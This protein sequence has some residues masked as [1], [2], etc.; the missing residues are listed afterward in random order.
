M[1]GGAVLF[2]RLAYPKLARQDVL[3]GSGLLL[4]ALFFFRRAVLGHGILFRRDISLVWYPQVESFVRSVAAGS[5]PLWD[6]YRGFG[7]PLLADPSAEILYPF[8][9]LNLVAQPWTVYAFFVVAHLTLSGVGIYAFAR[10][11]GVSR[12]GCLIAAIAWMASG[13]FLSLASTWHHMAGAAWIPWV[14]LAA[15][16]AWE[17]GALPRVL[18][19]GGA[20]AA[21][22]LAGSADMVAMTLVAVAVDALVH[23]FVWA[24]P[25]GPLNRKLARVAATAFVV[26][27]AFSAAQ[28]LPTL[29]M[30]HGTSRVNLEEQDR[31]TWSLH[32]LQALEMALPFHWND[33][34]L[35]R[36]SIET[37][38]GSREPW[39]H[40]VYLGLPFLALTV[41]GATGGASRRTGL[42]LLAFGAFLVALGRHAPAY[43]ILTAVL[44]P[45]RMLRFPVKALVIAT[46][47]AAVLAGFGVDRWREDPA[48]RGRRW[49]LRVTLPVA[50]LLVLTVA[51]VLLASV[52]TSWWAPAFL[53][54]D[55]GLP[56]DSV[57]LAPLS[58]RLL[59]AAVIGGV[60]LYLS[61]GKRVPGW[62]QAGAVG[63][64]LVVDL[65]FMHRDLHAVAP[66]AIETH[67]PEVLAY[68]GSPENRV[69]V[70]DYSLKSR[71]QQS[72]PPVASPFRPG[73][74]PAG[75]S[76]LPFV[77]FA[78]LTYLTPPTGGRWG[79]Y[80]SYDLDLLGLQPAPL[81]AL[82]DLLRRVEGSPAH[83][84]LL[85]MGGVSKMLDLAAP[86]RWP[87]LSLDAVVPGL[88]V[89]PIRV[90]DV[91]RPLPRAYVVGRAVCADGREALAR[92]VSPEF[93]PRQ[94]V[95]VSG[96]APRMET[97]GGAFSRAH[98]VDLKP[99]RVVVAAELSAPGYLVLLD[100][101]APGWRV[102]VD[103]NPAPLLQANI[104]FRAVQLGEGF[105]DVEFTYRPAAVY[106]G[107]VI[108]SAAIVMALGRSLLGRRPDP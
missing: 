107:L 101:Y 96:P 83:T 34:P 18:L 92:V 35:S 16:A 36:V 47:A 8:T 38:L 26:G 84:R 13:P 71:S 25:A 1:T 6:P 79:V 103:G 54:R 75:W 55:P 44:P 45:L 94:E 69:Y 56:G 14:F 10:R 27:L 49:R 32:P 70:Y 41:A 2:R 17:D 63:L 42:A 76:P 23:R 53:V 58:L 59:L 11:L 81:V 108:S 97:R 22:I 21:Q 46:F 19:W 61:E 87:D 5:W 57:M 82:N 102:S 12:G 72:R 43:G 85:Q 74:I 24:Q 29:A 100:A 91:P 77:T 39:I 3:A 104:A 7:Q 106:A 62:G 65:F 98:I 9:W 4:V 68:L 78:A 30:A 51:G 37:I 67:R 28:W 60:V 40:S 93:D 99:D 105:H 52:G 88:F 95:V 90:Y 66:K 64:A 89:Q 15:D 31:T 33:L 48:Q 50:L 80:G 86:A 73:P 20:I